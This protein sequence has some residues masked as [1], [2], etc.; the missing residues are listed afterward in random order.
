M[1]GIGKGVDGNAPELFGKEL[2]AHIICG[3][4][5]IS[6]HETTTKAE[7]IEKLRN[8]VYLLM[9]EGSTSATCQNVLEPLQKNAWILGERFSQLMIC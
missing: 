8:G 5:D 9:R 7:A 6:C 3:G 1:L 4:T 2:A